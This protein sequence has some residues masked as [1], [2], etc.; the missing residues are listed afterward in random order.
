M[1]EFVISQIEI[2]VAKKYF[3]EKKKSKMIQSDAQKNRFAYIFD[4]EKTNLNISSF[5]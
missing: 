5:K 2:K 1:G 4:E 3:Q